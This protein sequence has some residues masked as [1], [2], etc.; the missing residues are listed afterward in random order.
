MHMYRR[1]DCVLHS[2]FL[3]RLDR[4]KTDRN[5]VRLVYRRTSVALNTETMYSEPGP[6]SEEMGVC[7]AVC[8]RVCVWLCTHHRLGAERIPHTRHDL[9]RVVCGERL[10]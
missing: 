5:K 1:G 3:R 7:V 8:V 4:P 9:G 2:L 6:N 10:G